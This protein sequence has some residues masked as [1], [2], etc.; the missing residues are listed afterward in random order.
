MHIKRLSLLEGARAAR[1]TTVV[2]DVFRAFTCE[3]LMYHYGAER[4]YIEGDIERCLNMR[5]NAIL[6]GEKNEL[7]IEGFDLTNSPRLIRERGREFFGGRTVIHRTT[8]GATGAL[9]ALEGADEVL[10]ASYVIARATAQYVAWRNPAIVSIVAMG[11]RSV[12][13]APEDEYCGDYIEHLLTGK[14]YDHIEALRTVLAHETAQKFLRG[15]KP[16]LPP[17][18]P[19]ICLERDLFDFVLRAERGGELVAVRKLPCIPDVE[20][21]FL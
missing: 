20:V 10:L 7:P 9:A 3:P 6:V 13:K 12:E 2:I 16:Y 8:S 17:E 11:I 19:A 14:A 21:G 18:D 5:G 15:D 1:G 4:I